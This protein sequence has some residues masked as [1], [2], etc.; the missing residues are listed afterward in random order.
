MPSANPLTRDAEHRQVARKRQ[1]QKPDA[2]SAPGRTAAAA[3]RR[4]AG[5][6]GRSAR[7]ARPP[8]TG[9]HKR[10]HN[11]P[12]PAPSRIARIAQRAKVLSIPAKAR[13]TRKKIRISRDRTGRRSTSLATAPIRP[14]RRALASRRR[15]G[16]RA[17]E[18]ATPSRRASESPAASHAG[19]ARSAVA[20]SLPA[21]KPPSAG[22]MMKPRPKAAPISPMPCARFSGVVTSA[23]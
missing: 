15:A 11:R 19:V 7:P 5:S 14:R 21:R 3:P 18:T 4:S 17:A 10:R 12:A 13:M 8:T 23:I 1:D 16:S 20:G 22:P 2:R 6:G 9:R